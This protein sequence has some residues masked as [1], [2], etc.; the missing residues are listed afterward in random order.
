MAGTSAAAIPPPT[1]QGRSDREVRGLVTPESMEEHRH[2]GPIRRETVD[3]NVPMAVTRDVLDS[4][5]SSLPVADTSAARSVRWVGPGRVLAAI[6][7]RPAVVAF[8]LALLGGL[9]IAVLTPPM[10]GGDERDHFARAYQISQGDLLTTRHDGVYGAYLPRTYTSEVETLTVDSFLDRARTAFLRH[11]GDPAPHGS[12]TFV[13]VGNAASYGPGAYAAYAAAIA[14]GRAFGLS[15]LALLYVARMAG[16]V[17]YASLLALAVRR[18]PIHKWVL[19][20]CSLIPAAL[21]QAS[22]V[23]ADGVTMVLSFLIVAEAIR[24]VVDPQRPSR[25]LVVEAGVAAGFFALAKPPY[26]ALVLLFLWPAWR[27]RRTVGRGLTAIVAGALVLAAL[28]G[29]YQASHS[30]A[31]SNPNDWF[32][33]AKTV[34]GYAFRNLAVGRQTRHILTHPNA[35]VAAIGRTF[36]YQ[37]S[38]F[39]DQLFGQLALYQLPGWLVVAS[40]ALTVGACGAPD[41]PRQLAIPRPFRLQLLAVSLGVMLA[42][43]V[44]AYTN[45]NAYLAPRIDALPPRYFLPLIPP[46][47]IAVLPARTRSALVLRG[48]AYRASIALGLAGVLAFAVMGLHNY[49]YVHPPLR[50]AHLMAP[51]FD[52][53][54]VVLLQGARSLPPT[55]KRATSRCTIRAQCGPNH[56][57]SWLSLTP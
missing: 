51:N 17:L 38:A 47:L 28:W 10:T 1:P 55:I 27:H 32:G 29:T 4:E 19:V 41:E 9:A 36:A 52:G 34:H 20:A 3:N 8:C 14:V 6:A 42:I 22:T 23:S 26:V 56:P 30:I 44:I 25:R 48:P 53:G 12:P 11:L 37:G 15:V 46:L 43:F 45:W 13:S 16:V 31:Q 50:P 2:H 33:G 40:V 39:P 57:A 5:H 7:R 24:M 54:T 35:F 49:H 21:N 18:L